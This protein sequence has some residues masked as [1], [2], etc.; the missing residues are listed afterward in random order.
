MKLTG[1]EKPTIVERVVNLLPGP[2]FLKCLAFWVVFGTPGM[3]L[4]RYLDTFSF[5]R[6]VALFAQFDLQNVVFFSLPNFVLPLY[7]FY[8]I[9][10]MRLKVV[11]KMPELEA[12]A[13][14]GVRTLDEV[15]GSISKSLPAV[16]LAVLFG[17]V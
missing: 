1:A 2:Y 9:R 17:V 14:D 13:A 3:V 6:A 15:F 7:G 12:I 11:G 10:Y 8:G 4:T 5:D 16:A